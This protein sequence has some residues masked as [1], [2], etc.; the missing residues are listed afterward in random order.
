[1]S[2]CGAETLNALLLRAMRYSAPDQLKSTFRCP[3]LLMWQIPVRDSQFCDFIYCRT[4]CPQLG[5]KM[6]IIDHFVFDMENPLDNR[7][8][9][10]NGNNRVISSSSSSTQILCKETQKD[11]LV[12]DLLDFN[13]RCGFV[14]SWMSKRVT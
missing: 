11:L 3:T 2:R 10:T 13:W 9:Q 5:Y 1:L 6:S 7:Y 8:W 14:I 12:V 4:K